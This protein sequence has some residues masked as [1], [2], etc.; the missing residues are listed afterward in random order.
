MKL[1]ALLLMVT[2]LFC[3]SAKGQADLAD[4]TQI[5]PYIG[6]DLA[7]KR[8]P[9]AVSNSNG[10]IASIWEDDRNGLPQ[11]FLQI[12]DADRNLIGTNINLTPGEKI[13][14]QEY[15]LLVLPNDHFL[16]TW[17]SDEA[18]SPTIKY[19]IYAADGTLVMAPVAVEDGPDDR[20][21]RFPAIA[22]YDEST[23]VMSFVPYRFSEETIDVQLFSTSGEAVSERVALDTLTGFGDF[24]FSDVVVTEE[25][26]ILVTF[27][28]PIGFS[29]SNIGYALLDSDLNILRRN[30][31]INPTEGEA[32]HPSCVEVPD[33]N[34]A[35]FWLD[36]TNSF[37][38]ET[39][40]QL[41]EPDGDRVGS[42]KRIGLNDGQ[43]ISNQYP[44]PIRNGDRLALSNFPAVNKLTTLNDDLEPL[45]TIDF[46]GYR[47]YPVAMGNG[48]GAVFPQGL[49][50]AKTLAN[51]PFIVLQ[52]N[53]NQYQLNSDEFSFAERP[54]EWAFREDGTGVVLW[55]NIQ[56]GDEV[57]L[58]QRMNGAN[59][60]VGE[61][62]VVSTGSTNGHRIALADNGSFAIFYQE[63]E[64]FMTF[65]YLAFFDA[66]GNLIRTR[67]LGDTGGTAV[68]V[69]SRGV[70]YN[71]TSNQ[72]L[73]WARD[74]VNSVSRLRVRR[75]NLSGDF[76]GSYNTVL[77]EDDIGTFRWVVRDNG[78]YVAAYR[79]LNG[80]SN[81]NTFL[82]VLGQDA[83]LKAGPFQ[84]NETENIAG[85]NSHEIWKGSNGTIW[86][87][88]QYDG[89]NVG[90]DQLSS[91]IVIRSFS[92]E[93]TLGSEILM[94]RNGNILDRF[95]YRNGL[96]F[97]VQ[98]SGDIYQRRY[99]PTLGTFSERLFI[100]EA[101]LRRDFQ[102][103]RQGNGM[104]IL[105]REART[106]GRNYDLFRFVT[107]DQDQDGYFD[108]ID[109]DDTSATIFPGATEIVNNGIDEDCN[110]QDSTQ[111]TTS[112]M[113]PFGSEV[114]V[115]PNPATDIL[116]I[117]VDPSIP[118]QAAL[119]DMLG[120]PVLRGT[121]ARSFQVATLG[122][123]MYTLEL[124]RADK[125]GYFVQRIVVH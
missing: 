95:S 117:Q 60:R 30:R 84:F 52:R 58:G 62:F 28:R 124:V 85:S 18:F 87:R 42:A 66:A 53:D 68:L 36:F 3:L 13:E 120:Q 76:I 73:F 64:D 100:P 97:W 114:L 32:I 90:P 71:P 115:Y 107:T 89:S 108:I 94:D 99:S 44:R 11:L 113:E 39:Y 14:E 41:I 93:N 72:Y 74:F 86:V 106:P 48:F 80:F 29:D 123:G 77:N 111:M 50:F 105:F 8:F 122:P 112:T 59:E 121:N 22:L 21:S 79:K 25:K 35:V 56:N 16:I 98:R 9:K 83:Q 20:G 101:D 33:G 109:C 88:Y 82:L 75:V 65:Y 1:S 125:K 67:P 38:G 51:A 91:P 34:L 46:E 5:N 10:D 15:D 92:S 40:G 116:Q 19:A 55:T 7:T 110:G 63:F 23:F 2:F 24:E 57:T 69:D 103:V 26:Q 6:D 70:E 78:D 12:T 119:R 49:R 27:Q 104:T 81:N 45:A 17:S 47:C 96:W 43:V 31:R 37:Q 102:F 61:P 54:Q 118:Y 4:A